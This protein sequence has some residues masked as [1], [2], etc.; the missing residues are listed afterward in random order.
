MPVEKRYKSFLSITL[1]ILAFFFM[2]N[3]IGAKQGCCSWHGGVAGCDTS[4]GR[5]VCNDGTYSPSCTCAYIPNT[6]TPT[7]I[8]TPSPTPKPTFTPTPTPTTT[9]SPTSQIVITASPTNPPSASSEVKGETTQGGSAT[10]WLVGAGI[11]SFV[12]WRLLKWVDSKAP[13]IKS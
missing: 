4:V 10:N 9:P 5:Q 3:G 8:F 12:L 11:G 7:R 6:P 13:E 1:F 2:P